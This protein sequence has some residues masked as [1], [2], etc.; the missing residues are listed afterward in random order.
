M[1]AA[2]AA[3]TVITV[4]IGLGTQVERVRM[5]EAKPSSGLVELVSEHPATVALGIHP[6]PVEPVVVRPDAQTTCAVAR[7]ATPGDEVIFYWVS[8]SEAP[9]AKP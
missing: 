1:T 9:E 4:W 2:V 7:V 6:N 3:A 8:P 5:V